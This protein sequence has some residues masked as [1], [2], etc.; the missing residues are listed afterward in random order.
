[1]RLLW[2]YEHDFAAI[3]PFLSER[4]GTLCR[5]LA[6]LSGSIRGPPTGALGDLRVTV[7]ASPPR[8]APMH[9]PTLPPGPGLSLPVTVGTLLC[10][11]ELL[12]PRLNQHLGRR[13]EP[14]AGEQRCWSLLFLKRRREQRR[15][16]PRWRAGRRILCFVLILLITF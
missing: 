16:F 7:R 9:H 8:H 13:V 10:P 6:G 14:L 2:A 12:R 11:P 3:S 4:I 1:M 15:S 5:H